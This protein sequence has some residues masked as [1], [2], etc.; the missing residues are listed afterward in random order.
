MYKIIIK[1]KYNTITLEVNDLQ[2]TSLQ[3]ILEQPY[4]E[5]VRIEHKKEKE[6]K[7]E[8]RK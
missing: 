5:E 8:I 1:T 6:L 2:D 4:I 7:R 3:E